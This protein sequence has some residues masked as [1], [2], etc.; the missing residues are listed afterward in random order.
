MCKDVFALNSEA[1]K[2]MASHLPGRKSQVGGRDR[3]VDLDPC[4]NPVR[5]LHF[6]QNLT[7]FGEL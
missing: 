4:Q 1:G 3:T 2:E 5:I 6:C 7:L